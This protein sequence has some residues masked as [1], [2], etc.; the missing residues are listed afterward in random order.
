[1]SGQRIRVVGGPWPKR[2]GCL[3]R[4]V[5]ALLAKLNKESDG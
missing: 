5:D 3:G 4:I 1:M 2:I